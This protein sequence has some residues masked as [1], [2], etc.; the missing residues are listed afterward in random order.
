MDELTPR[1]KTVLRLV[2]REY[3]RNAMPVSSRQLAD[4]YGLE[5]S[6]ATIRN[7][8]ARLEDL[9]YLTHPHTSAGRVPTAEGYRFFV[10]R[11]MGE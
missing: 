2:V 8:L 3:V 1:Q 4:C 5:V 7:D 11:L 9:G 10:G 6:T